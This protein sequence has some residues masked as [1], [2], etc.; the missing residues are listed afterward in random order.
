MNLALLQLGQRIVENYFRS[1]R[2]V[3]NAAFDAFIDHIPQDQV[4]SC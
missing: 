4:L 1:L 3:T 2:P